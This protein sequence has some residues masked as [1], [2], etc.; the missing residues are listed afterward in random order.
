MAKKAPA[1]PEEIAN[2]SAREGQFFDRWMNRAGLLSLPFAVAAGAAAAGAV[3]AAAPVVLPI[4]SG[5]AAG[6]FAFYV[7]SRLVTHI[8]HDKNPGL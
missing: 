4:A 7:G 6:T 5:V 2:Q 1:T 8:R 3:V